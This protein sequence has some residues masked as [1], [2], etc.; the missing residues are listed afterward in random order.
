MM[1]KIKQY[2]RWIQQLGPD[3]LPGDTSAAEDPRCRPYHRS[4]LGAYVGK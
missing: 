2:D 3:G 1:I 4:N